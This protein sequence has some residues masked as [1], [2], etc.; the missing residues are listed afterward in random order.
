MHKALDASPSKDSAFY[1]SFN[2][3]FSTKISLPMI[4][5]L[6][7]FILPSKINFQIERTLEQKMDTRTDKLNLGAGLGFYAINMFGNLGYRPTFKFYQ[8]DE[9]S[10]S[11]DVS[12][13]MPKNE[14]VSYRV[15]SV[16]GA[17]FKG[18]GGGV[19]SFVN[20]FTLKSENYWL[21]SFVSGWEVPLK[22]SIL[23]NF[24]KKTVLSPEKQNSW[25][26]LSSYFGTQYEQLRKETLELVF[27][28]QTDF[29]R[30]SLIAGHEEIVRIQGK[31]NFSAYIKLRGGEDKEN[32]TLIFDVILGTA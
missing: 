25:F 9:Y 24:Y 8:T 4:Y 5:N 2:D 21:E 1:S 30:W 11:I 23:G 14:E 32:K 29:L 22:K 15:Q 3:H 26:K 20:T 13:Y 12:V 18:A 19:L 17:G 28:R 7:A 16:L 31:L 10:H 6:S 27:D